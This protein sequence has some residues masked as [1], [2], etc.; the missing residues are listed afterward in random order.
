MHFFVAVT[1]YRRND[2]HL[3]P[4]PTSNEAADLLR[5]QQIKLNYANMH[6]T[7]ARALTRD[8]RK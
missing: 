8:A 5:T 2:L 1:F 4:T 3:R 7:A 6:A